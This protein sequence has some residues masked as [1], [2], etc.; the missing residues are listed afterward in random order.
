[1]FLIDF[2]CFFLSAYLRGK[3]AIFPFFFSLQPTPTAYNKRA[4]LRWIHHIFIG[5]PKAGSGV[6]PAADKK[7]HKRK[8]SDDAPRSTPNPDEEVPKGM[9]GTLP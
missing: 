2:L 5:M 7:A 9:P 8:P 6:A 4:T 1:M 3:N